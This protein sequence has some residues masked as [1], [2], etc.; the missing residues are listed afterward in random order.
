MEDP[1]VVNNTTMT[2]VEKAT[3]DSFD[4]QREVAAGGEKGIRVR[5]L[6]AAVQ[7]VR[8]SSSFKTPRYAAGTPVADEGRR[9]GADH[10]PVGQLGQGVRGAVNIKLAVLPKYLCDGELARHGQRA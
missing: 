3:F 7:G 9:S 8:A 6:E 4:L 5:G 10:L 2:E 1:T